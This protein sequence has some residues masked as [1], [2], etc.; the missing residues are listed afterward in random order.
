MIKQ[1]KIRLNKAFV[2]PLSLFFLFIMVV[3][4]Y[5][6]IN[7]NVQSKKQQRATIME[8]KAYF[9]ALAGLQQF[10]L[11]YS[12]L[13]EEFFKSNTIYYGFSPFYIPPKGKPFDLFDDPTKAGP[14]YYPEFLAAYIEDINSFYD[15]SLDG[16]AKGGKTTIGVRTLIK[17]KSR[18]VKQMGGIPTWHLGLGKFPLEDKETLD[19]LKGWGYKV[20][21]FKC[22]SL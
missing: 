9:M 12:M 20:S 11:K 21:F 17:S 22:G 2:L 19:S 4:G 7:I 18:E 13:P 3:F 6:L 1:K 14:F 10:K 16:S 5:M 8:T 15:D